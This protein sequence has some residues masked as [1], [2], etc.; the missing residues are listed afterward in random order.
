[1]ALLSVGIVGC[2]AESTTPTA[3]TLSPTPSPATA[4]CVGDPHAHVY[5]PDR[6]KLLAPC[7]TVAATIERV[8]AQPDGDYH[9]DLKL[10]PGE[11]CA[12]QPCLD[13]ANVSQ[14]A[15]DLV[16]EPVCENPITQAD[17][18][19]GCRGYHNPLVVPPE[20]SHVMATG[21]FVLDLDHGWNEI[22]PLESI[23]VVPGPTPSAASSPSPSTA[24]VV[25]YVTIT[26]STY[27]YIAATTAP[28]ASCTARAKLPS[29]RIST[30][31]G[32]TV[33]VVAGDDGAV[34]WSY[35]TPSTTKPGTGTHTVSCTLAGKTASASAAFTVT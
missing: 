26:S 32:L 20:G 14:Q 8:I 24:P 35:G 25:L 4:A 16:T 18:V 23:T 9:V 15:G 28:G 12:G 29:G 2:S 10:D 17:A 1:M 31:A 6:L 33:T 34:S 3:A 30:A 19:A 27:G 13:Q 7:V 22:H 11:T 5:S 21:P